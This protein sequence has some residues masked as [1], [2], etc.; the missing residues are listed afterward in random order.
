LTRTDLDDDTREHLASWT[1]SG[2]VLVLAGPPSA[3]P[4]AL[5]VSAATTSK[6]RDLTARSPRSRHVE[7]GALASDQALRVA[8]DA[9]VVA[10]F[11][12]ETA[13][14]VAIRHGEGWVVGLATD[15]LFTN[16]ALARPGNAAVLIAILSHADRATFR[17]AQAE[18]GVSPPSS[19]IAVLTRAGLGLGLAHAVIAALVVFL[20]A[21]VRLARPRPASPPRRRAFA[22]HVRAVG[23]LYARTNSSG[24]ALHA[25]VRFVVERVRARMPHGTTD[26]PAFLAS[27]SR[28]P[29]DVCRSVWARATGAGSGAKSR[30]DLTTLKELSTIYASAMARDK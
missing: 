14:A 10:S 3:W 23:A 26:V 9:D 5:G 16:A 8:G 7:H 15:E 2:G 6:P 13:Y 4:A 19:P 22:E 17:M 30:D 27:R 18:D 29:L 24:H 12:D 20:A 25:Y 28:L 21:G 11:A 1:Q